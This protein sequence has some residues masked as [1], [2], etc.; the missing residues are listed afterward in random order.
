[1]SVATAFSAASSF[2]T[3]PLQ[4]ARTQAKRGLR[5]AG[6]DND[7]SVL[8]LQVLT[9]IR[10]SLSRLN[11]R[12]DE[13]R[14]RVIVLEQRDQWVSMLESL[15]TTLDARVDVLLKDKDRRDGAISAWA[16]L[17]KNV[18]AM[19]IGGLF[20]AAVAWAAKHFS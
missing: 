13:T 2:A 12:M 3:T 4:P 6:N 16:W 18:P 17:S 19:G 14:E 7:K 20:T 15:V 10:D 9:E 11:S 1:M 8:E 5:V